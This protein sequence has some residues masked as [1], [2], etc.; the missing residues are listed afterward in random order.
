MEI[1]NTINTQANLGNVVQS[2][3]KDQ[4]M[5]GV[6]M[7]GKVTKVHHKTNTADV[8]LVRSNNLL[9]GSDTKEGR[10]SCRISSSFSMFNTS[11]N[12]SSGVIEPIQKDQ[13][14]MVTFL[15]GLKAQPVI[16]GSLSYP[17]TEQ[18]ISTG[19]YPL[20]IT[21]DDTD[22]KES[23]KY[24]RVFPSQDYYKVDGRGNMEIAFHNKSFISFSEEGLSDYSCKKG[25]TA[26]SS[27]S[28]KSK[29]TGNTIGIDENFKDDTGNDYTSY[30]GAKDLLMIFQTSWYDDQATWTKV[31]MDCTSDTEA[32]TLR[33]TRDNSDNSLS[34]FELRNS[35]EIRLRR[36]LDSDEHDN[37]NCKYTEIN[38]DRSGNVN[39]LADGK[40]IINSDKDVIINC[41]KLDITCDSLSINE[42]CV[43][44]VHKRR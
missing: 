23:L 13:L 44:T 30:I 4:N 19:L 14:V 1:N 34:F 9:A 11:T 38:I 15:D 18:N 17:D 39:I 33:I 36:Q 25:G 3:R 24:L 31:F 7:L 26:H 22:L 43:M 2:T 37:E 12:T 32:G 20:N 5:Y 21:E 27:L 35:G 8:K 42:D 16:I 28:E 29:F 10:F 41:K 40:L 6:I